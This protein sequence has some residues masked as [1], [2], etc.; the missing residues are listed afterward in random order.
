MLESACIYVCI[1]VTGLNFG[2]WKTW[3]DSCIPEENSRQGCQCRHSQ[4][5]VSP[6]CMHSA[7]PTEMGEQTILM[8]FGD[9]I[10]ALLMHLGIGYKRKVHKS[11]GA[12]VWDSGTEQLGQL[13]EGHQPS[14]LAILVPLMEQ[15]YIP[16]ELCVLF[17]HLHV[18]RLIWGTLS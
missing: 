3:Q 13:L 2:L 9:L 4:I 5:L 8:S 11:L 14:T 1:Y 6:L 18:P 7:F 16:V 15:G 17:I 10:I 12:V